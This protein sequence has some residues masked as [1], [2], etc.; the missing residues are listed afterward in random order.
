MNTPGPSRRPR[1]I[2]SSTVSLDGRVTFSRP[3]RLLDPGIRQRWQACWPADVPELIA[4]RE[5]DIEDRHHPTVVMEGS[6]TFVADE[7]GPVAGVSH[8]HE[9]ADLQ[10]DWLPKQSPKWFA[11]VDGR[12][13]VSWAFTGAGDMSLLVLAGART[14][15]RYLAWLRELE[16]PYLVAGEGRVN[17]SVALA[18][19]HDL[20]SARCVVSEG[21][22]GING[23]LLRAGLVDEVQMYESAT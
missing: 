12:G 19:M 2:V 10:R 4:Q 23:A 22:G 3:E 5:A 9:T 20:L 7:A 6:G 8:V 13:R 14:P 1:V 18:K 16:V 17:L 11:V 21:G 15:L